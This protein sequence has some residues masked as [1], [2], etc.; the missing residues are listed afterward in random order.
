VEKLGQILIKEGFVSEKQLDE[1]LEGHK[2]AN[3]PLGK[4]LVEKG[5]V[6]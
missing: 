5:Y 1:V 6:T 2:D 3:L 4:V